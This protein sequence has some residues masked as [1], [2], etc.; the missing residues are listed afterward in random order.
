MF[1]LWSQF[2]S[3]VCRLSLLKRKTRVP[4]RA[5]LPHAI[6]SRVQFGASF[7]FLKWGLICTYWQN[8]CCGAFQ[9]LSTASA[10]ACATENKC[11]T[12][13]FNVKRRGDGGED[14]NCNN[15]KQSARFRINMLNIEY[16]YHLF[17]SLDSSCQV[18]L[19]WAFGIARITV[20][21]PRQ[22]YSLS[23]CHWHAAGAFKLKAL[24]WIYSVTVGQFRRGH[25][26]SHGGGRT[27]G[28]WKGSW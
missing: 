9:Q 7:T 20:E 24:L 15:S 1:L 23:D 16:F 21:T 3:L 22:V 27:A 25:T 14:E 26:C 18:I 8:I 5:L 4:Q 2:K 17:K 13:R 11:K 12:W 10:A 28:C 6:N 19:R